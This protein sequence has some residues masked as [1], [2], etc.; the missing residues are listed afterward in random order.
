M[1]DHHFHIGEGLE[2]NI[3]ELTNTTPS[4]ILKKWKDTNTNSILYQVKLQNICSACGISPEV[5]QIDL[6]NQ[7][8]VMEKMYCNLL[9]FFTHHK[10]EHSVDVLTRIQREIIHIWKKLDE[11]RIFHNDINLCNILLRTDLTVF[12][13]DFGFSIPCNH[14]KSRTNIKRNPQSFVKWIQDWN[15][16]NPQKKIPKSCYDL[17]STVK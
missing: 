5:Y 14:T 13:I 3:F 11:L 15:K 17:I 6:P 4:H 9:T 2:A 8:I 12:L 16:K 7:S 10:H 1:P